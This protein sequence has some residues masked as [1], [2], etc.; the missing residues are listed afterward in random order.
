MRA[1]LRGQQFIWSNPDE[2]AA[3]AAGVLK[4]DVAL[5]RRSL[6]E[7]I[8]LGILDPKLDWSEIGLRRIY[9]NMQADGAIPAE[10]KFDLGKV[11]DA[12]YLRAAQGS[13]A[14]DQ[15]ESKL[16]ARLRD[17]PYL[18]TARSFPAILDLQPGRPHF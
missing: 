6:A 14:S 12:E 18:R 15:G 10:R 8:R 16:P 17:P 4:T 3:I 11:T 9:E 2:A 13:V 5:A 7:A 1:L